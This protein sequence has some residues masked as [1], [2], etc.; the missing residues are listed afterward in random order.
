MCEVKTSAYQEIPQGIT[1]E[2]AA[3]GVRGCEKRLTSLCA[4]S[5]SFRR[6]L[7]AE[8]SVQVEVKW[9]TVTEDPVAGINQ[10]S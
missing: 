4:Q 10:L 7:L 9:L 1:E 3:K 6:A 5:T 8:S 2:G